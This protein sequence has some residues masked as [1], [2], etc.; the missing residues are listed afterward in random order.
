MFIVLG[1]LGF[2]IWGISNMRERSD[3]QP[4]ATETIPAIIDFILTT[5]TASEPTHEPEPE[6]VEEVAIPTATAF[7]VQARP[8]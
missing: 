2:L 8:E 1:I 6:E 7:F 3:E 5:P 4:V